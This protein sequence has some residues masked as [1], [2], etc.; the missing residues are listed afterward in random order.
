MLCSSFIRLLIDVRLGSSKVVT[1][2]IYDYDDPALVASKVGQ[3]Y[4]LDR[5]VVRLLEAEVRRNMLQKDIPIAEGGDVEEEDREWQG[6]GQET[7]A[8]ADA[9]SDVSDDAEYTQFSTPMGKLSKQPSPSPVSPPSAAGT[10]S[11]SPIARDT[12]IATA[13]AAAVGG[14]REEEE[15]TGGGVGVDLVNEEL[16]LF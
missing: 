2:N 3:I 8:E 9:M 5:E 11:R 6:Q 13:T 16:S 1:I 10:R 7:V 12:V 14:G 15:G 4:A